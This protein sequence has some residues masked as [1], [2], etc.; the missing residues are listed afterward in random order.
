MK[1]SAIW[2]LGLA[3]TGALAFAVAKKLQERASNEAGNDWIA[4]CDEASKK[5]QLR[6]ESFQKA[7]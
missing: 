5:L 4:A 6:I 3:A 7:S 2:M 1:K